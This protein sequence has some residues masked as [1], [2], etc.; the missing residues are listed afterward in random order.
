MRPGERIAL[1]VIALVASVS[2]VWMLVERMVPMS[3]EAPAVAPPLASSVVPPVPPP[4]EV[5]TPAG[6]LLGTRTGE[7]T[8][9]L[10]VPF[11]LP[12]T[13]AARFRPPTRAPRASAPIDARTAGPVCPQIELRGV[14]AD[15]DERLDMV[16][17]EDCLRLN[18]WTRLDGTARP[19]MVFIHGGGFQRGGGGEPHFGRSELVRRGDVVL[20][21]VHYRLGALGMIAF[22]AL[23]RE[24]ESGS[25]GNYGLR[26]QIA[27][28]EWVRDNIASL[29]GDPTRVTIFGESAGGESVCALIASPL[30]QGLFAQAISES[31]GGC[32]RWPTFREGIDGR[33]SG[34]GRGNEI[35]A[36]AGCSSADDVAACMRDLD[37]FALV[38]AATRGEHR[39]HLP[40]FGPI[41]D[42]TVLVASAYDRIERGEVD[43]PLIVGSNA[44]EASAFTMFS[45]VDDASYETQLRALA[46]PLADAA[47]TIWPSTL[48]DT[49]RASLRRAFGEL[50]FVCPAEDLARVAA[51]GAYPSYLYRF[52]R[53]IPGA[54]GEHFGAF[55][56]VEL[57]YLFANP[58]PGLDV[59]PA[60]QEVVDTMHAAWAGFATTGAPMTTLRWPAYATDAPAILRIDS[61]SMVVPDVSEGRCA[62][63]RAAGIRLPL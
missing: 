31:G 63:A 48:A 27:A 44:D 28:L 2:I 11:A 19:V 29:G 46:G 62:R 47:L 1:S 35:V 9:F 15:P 16:G 55:H 58:I 14:L 10:G 37:A 60:D 40:V 30:A 54:I 45:R 59:A 12:P 39:L 17:D 49:P 50:L 38:R 51:A 21:T 18:V 36:S 6:T 20:V 7:V 43:T 52:D 4:V 22:D 41:I 13:G 8:S 33:L 53:Q 34:L 56:G 61:P 32:A 24:S 3:L 42:G 57:F 25:A 26:D 23:T 5:E